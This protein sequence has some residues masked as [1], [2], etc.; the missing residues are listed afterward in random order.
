MSW[1]KLP[2][3]KADRRPFLFR[4]FKV[5]LKKGTVRKPLPSAKFNIFLK[6]D[7]RYQVNIA[8]DKALMNTAILQ[9]Y[10]NGQLLG[11]TFDEGKNTFH[12]SFGFTAPR[13]GSYQVV[14][15]SREGKEGCIAG[16]MSLLLDKP[17][18]S[19]SVA[20]E[21]QEELE[22][23]YLQ[24]ENPVSIITDKEESDSIYFETDNGIIREKSGS[25]FLIPS[26]EGI[27]TLKVII[28]NSHG[29][30]K[31]EARSDFLVRRLPVPTASIHGMHGG[32][33]AR[34][35][36]QLADGIEIN[37]PIEFEMYGFEVLDFSVKT[38]EGGERRISNP[39]K[40]FSPAVKNS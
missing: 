38:G 6:S 36:L 28:K 27:C 19:D 29:K 16:I 8:S 18:E 21:K 2:W 17:L 20:P 3:L 1:L 24:V 5:K 13:T 26:N 34:S 9:V 12:N 11:G 33:I 10:N 4:E 40:N 22:V 30:I 31:E 15:S 14:I 32:I 39:G 35:A 23:L 37:S 7:N 25:Y